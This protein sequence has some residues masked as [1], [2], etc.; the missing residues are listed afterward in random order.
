MKVKN[1]L[2]ALAS[3]GLFGSVLPSVTAAEKEKPSADVEARVTQTIKA[4]FPEVVI[5]KMGTETEDGLTF[6]G[7]DFTSKGTKIEADVMAD[8]LL[9]GS[10]A[11]GD[12]KTFPKAAVKALKKATKGMTIKETEI[13]TTYAKA[14]PNDK[15]GLKAI[16]LQQRIIAYEMVVEKDGHKGE[17]SVDADGKILESP[18]WAKQGGKSEGKEDKD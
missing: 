4:N 7:V 17:F 15:T 12:L 18:K 13:A 14:D 8:G 10:E 16:K 11:A 6:I 1:I 5:T 3:L 2:L 9:V